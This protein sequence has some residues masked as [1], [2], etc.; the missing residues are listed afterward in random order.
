M[1]GYIY[2]TTDTKGGSVYVGQHKSEAYDPSYLGSGLLISR[3]ANKRAGSL[4]NYVLEWCETKDAL[5]E[6]ERKWIEAFR[7]ECNCL[8]ISD[9]GTGGNLGDMVNARIG[10]AMRGK[11]FTDD[12]KSNL[13]ASLRKAFSTPEHIA[14][15]PQIYNDEYKAKM[16]VAVATANTPE[17][18]RRKS[19]SHRGR[20]WV[21]NEQGATSIYP[22]E[23]QSYLD[24]GFKR[25]LKFKK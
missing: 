22:S 14:K 6:A 13:S 24:R 15:K 1:Y 9:G 7:A 17:V 12:H 11:T 21:C 2:I 19:E 16:S 3:I 10:D 8:N 25:G 5:N 23:L 18:R 20:V 4:C